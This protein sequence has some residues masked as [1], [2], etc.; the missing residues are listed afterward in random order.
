MAGHSKWHSIKHK[1]A[2]TDN[3]RGKVLTKHAKLLAVVGRNDPNPETN[4][5]LRVAIAN[6]K[7]DSVPKDNIERILKKI[8]GEGKDGVVYS[9]QVY[10]GFGPDGVPIMIT[11]L[12]EN[13]NRTFPF[14]RIAFTKN[15]GN[16]GTPGSVGF[17]FDHVG[18]ITIKTNEKT[19]DDLFEAVMNAN[20]QDFTYDEEI[21]EVI[22]KFTDLGAVRDALIEQNIDVI[23][24]GPEYRIKDPRVITDKELYEKLENFI[25]IIENVDDV[26]EVFTGFVPDDSLL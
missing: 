14:V 8:S 5:S 16:L 21:C 4:A 22:T 2:A 20:G 17:L 11:A 26:D 13:N 25:D 6:A 24:I 7:A 19:E 12:T 3:K 18:V 23:K 10:E 9:Q 15:G 1:K